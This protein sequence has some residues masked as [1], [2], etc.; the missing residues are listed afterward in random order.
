MV[1]FVLEI[2]NHDGRTVS[3][4][5]VCDGGE[6]AWLGYLSKK[7]KSV[8]ET[9][10]WRAI[11]LLNMQKVPMKREFVFANE[12]N[13]WGEEPSS[14]SGA[15]KEDDRDSIPSKVLFA[16]KSPE[17]FESNKSKQVGGESNNE[18]RVDDDHDE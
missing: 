18:K 7:T 14:S 2:K 4:A 16:M 12:K 8:W 5:E 10:V 9:V 17:K 13:T 6:L 15:T 3:M 1:I 11:S